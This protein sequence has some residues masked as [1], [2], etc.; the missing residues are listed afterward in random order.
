MCR[1]LYSAGSDLPDLV[2][3]PVGKNVLLVEHEVFFELPGSIYWGTRWRS[4]LMHCAT[5]RKVAGSIP[6]GVIGICHWHI[7][8]R[9]HYG[10]GVDSVSNRNEY[11]EYFLRVKAAGA[12][13]WQPYHFQVTV[14][15]KSGSLNFLEPLGPVEACNGIAFIYSCLIISWYGRYIFQRDILVWHTVSFCT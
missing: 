2:C 15:L 5:S 10:F 13:G 8:F 6:D 9:P 11:Q 14:V 1:T 12:W 3:L 7:F 4:W